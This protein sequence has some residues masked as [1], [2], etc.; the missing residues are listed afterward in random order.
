MQNGVFTLPFTRLPLS[1]SPRFRPALCPG[2]APSPLPPCQRGC[3]LEKIMMEETPALNSSAGAVGGWVN[4]AHHS[5][6]SQIS[7]ALLSDH[8]PREITL[9]PAPRTSTADGSGSC[10][11]THAVWEK[12]I[13][14][15]IANWA[16]NNLSLHNGKDAPL[17]KYIYCN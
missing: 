2:P 3:G 14:S 6:F 17:K 13:I 15:A 4:S 7:A 12:V 8:Q 16:R 9:Q 1:L 11:L 10:S 5:V